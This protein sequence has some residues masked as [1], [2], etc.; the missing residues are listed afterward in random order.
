MIA[1]D[2]FLKGSNCRRQRDDR[3]RR[4]RVRHEHVRDVEDVARGIPVGACRSGDGRETHEDG[5]CREKG[6]VSPRVKP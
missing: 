4:R 1:T 2:S 6:P 3:F 5:D